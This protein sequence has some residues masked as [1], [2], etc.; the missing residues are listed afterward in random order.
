MAKKY[1]AAPGLL[2]RVGR[3]ILAQARA[4][5]THPHSLVCSLLL[6]LALWGMALAL[7]RADVF[8][9]ARVELPERPA[10][11]LPQSVIGANLWAVDLQALAA[12]LKAQQPALRTVRVI[13]Q[14]PNT[15]RIEA[16][17]RRPV[18]V[19]Q[20]GSWYPVDAG[21][22]VLPEP[23]SL[24][25]ESMVRLTGLSQR[26]VKPGRESADERLQLALRL[27]AR[28]KQA[29]PLVARHL[30]EI[31]VADDHEI[32]FLLRLSAQGDTEVRCGS[33]QELDQQLR[34]LQAALNVMTR[35]VLPAR[36]IDVR[37]PEPVIA[38]RT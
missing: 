10:L 17:P 12:A 4:I 5:A 15:L 11:S 1:R 36:Y 25:Q 16:V 34:R 13:R 35:Q 7:R 27:L 19:V 37:F 23:S 26:S 31:D 28:L 14:L 33:E 29:P 38:P 8:R 6:G 2:P 3:W 20:L 9:I 30:A 32:R 22:F 24:P 18:A 21:G